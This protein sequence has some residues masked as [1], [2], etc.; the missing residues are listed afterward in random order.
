VWNAWSAEAAARRVMVIGVLLGSS[1]D[2]AGA[3]A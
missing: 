3:V 1:T 2:G